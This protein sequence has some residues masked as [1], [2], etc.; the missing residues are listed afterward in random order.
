MS[1]A[2]LRGLVIT[3]A[4]MA[5]ACMLLT[6]SARG[7]T[8]ALWFLTVPAFCIV[9][10]VRSICLRVR[11]SGSR[12]ELQGPWRKAAGS[13]DD[14][15][16]WDLSARGEARLLRRSD[17]RWIHIPIIDPGILADPET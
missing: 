6:Q 2:A 14:F 16:G 1:E 9:F 12:F 4:A 17:L 11:F 15:L 13:A 10:A 5:V 8:G 7:D 3:G